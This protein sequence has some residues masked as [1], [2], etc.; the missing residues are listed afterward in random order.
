MVAQRVVLDGRDLRTDRC[1]FFVRQIHFRQQR[2]VIERLHRLAPELHLFPPRPREA[3]LLH[4]RLAREIVDLL[5]DVELHHLDLVAPRRVIG[6]EPERPLY[7]AHSLD[8]GRDGI[9]H[10]LRPVEEDA[11]AVI[12]PLDGR[13]ERM[14]GLRQDARGRLDAGRADVMHG[15]GASFLL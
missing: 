3:E 1:D 6:I 15:E 2:A 10:N 5:Q 12:E 13:A 11:V 14:D 7:D 8:I 4:E 9:S